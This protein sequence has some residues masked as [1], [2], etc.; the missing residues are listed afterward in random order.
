M[1][2][3]NKYQYGFILHYSFENRMVYHFVLKMSRMGHSLE[4]H[5]RRDYTGDNLHILRM[6]FSHLHDVIVHGYEI[7]IRSNFADS[8]S[9]LE[10][11]V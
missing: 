2:A 1:K 3:I 7:Y 8:N 10:N 5:Q 4:A 6:P 9:C 11:M